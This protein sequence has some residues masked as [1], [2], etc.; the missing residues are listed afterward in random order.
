MA[1][2]LGQLQ[3]WHRLGCEKNLTF[4]GLQEQ[5][6]SAKEKEALG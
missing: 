1:L 4:E 5:L 2:I 3:G 6:M